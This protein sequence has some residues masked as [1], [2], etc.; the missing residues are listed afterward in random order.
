[1]GSLARKLKRNQER[2]AFQNFSKVF[3][4]ERYYQRHL[5]DE[6]TE[7][8]LALMA[9]GKLNGGV[10]DPSKVAFDLKTLLNG[11]PL[12]G[13]KPP[14]TVWKKAIAETRAKQNEAFKERA[15]KQLAEDKKDLEWKDNG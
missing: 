9:E 3:M 1:M 15:A 13:K 14:F 7:R 2:I 6:E 11:N 8:Q 12:L 4:G 10:I 5:I